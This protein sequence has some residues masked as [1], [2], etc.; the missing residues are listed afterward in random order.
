MENKEL[1]YRLDRLVSLLVRHR[2]SR[3]FTCG[4]RLP[5][6]LRQAGHYVSRTVRATRWDLD[7]VH[8]QCN[9]CNVVLGGNI[10][11]YSAKLDPMV[12]SRLDA[13]KKLYDNGKLPEPTYKEKIQKYNE[14]LGCAREKNCL[15]KSIE[16]QEVK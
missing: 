4:R 10:Q 6:N 14:L 13:M 15:P 2:E 1:T 5:F 8:V 3:C 12:R 7:N 9:R 16:W 11:V